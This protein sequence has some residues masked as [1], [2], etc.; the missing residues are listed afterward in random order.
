MAESIE[1]LKKELALYKQNGAVGL[2]YELNKFVNKT[3][4]IMRSTSIEGLLVI[5]DSPKEGDSKKSNKIDDPKKFEKIMA[6]IKNAKEHVND[7]MEMKQKFALTGDEKT[8]KEKKP[9]VETIAQS[10]F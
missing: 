3:V 5:E 6:L 1:D 9:F 2:Y 10:R 8:D 7:M 4:E